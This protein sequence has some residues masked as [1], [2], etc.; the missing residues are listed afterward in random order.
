MMP[1]G[2]LSPGSTTTEAHVLYIL[3][4]A[5]REATAVG[6]LCNSYSPKQK[7]ALSAVN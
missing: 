7:K 3:L 5:T 6:S 1:H 2:N 4:S